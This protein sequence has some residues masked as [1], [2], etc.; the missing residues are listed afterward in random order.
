MDGIGMGVPFLCW[1]YVV[2]QFHNQSY[3]CDKWK[4][5]LGLNPD[6]NGFISRHEIKKKIEMLVSDDVIKANAEK[7]KEMTRK[8]VSEGGS[9]YK[10]FQTFVE[11]MKQ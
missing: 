10:N 3:I 2:D 9:S 5:G 7:L 4:V 1:P 6:E 8:S 11:V